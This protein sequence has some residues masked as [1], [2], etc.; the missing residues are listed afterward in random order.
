MAARPMDNMLQLIFTS[1]EA[2]SWQQPAFSHALANAIPMLLGLKQSSHLQNSVFDIP[3]WFWKFVSNV[4]ASAN[5]KLFDCLYLILLG[6]CESF[7]KIS[8]QQEG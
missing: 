7:A 2:L 1:C 4:V 6:T 3:T 8:R 5:S